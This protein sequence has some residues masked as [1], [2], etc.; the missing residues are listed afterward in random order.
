M[1]RPIKVE[2]F[3]PEEVLG[4]PADAIRS[5][6]FTDEPLTFRVGTAEILGAFRIT[7]SRLVVELAHVD[8]GGEGVLVTIAALCT[9]YAQMRELA[10]IEWIVLAVHCAR[11]NLALRR[12]LD[13]RGFQVRHI[14]GIGPAYHRVDHVE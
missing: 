14:S 12:L 5:F 9:R 3:T 6:V 10:E 2:G 1:R 8:G 13:N 4:L 11:P 7:G